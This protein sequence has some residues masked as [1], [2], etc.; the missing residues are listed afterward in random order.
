M[1]S[2]TR[3]AG[4]LLGLTLLAGVAACSSHVAA[5]GAGAGAAY[6]LTNR[7][8]EGMA[9]GSF[10]EV[11]QNSITVM[12]RMGITRT[13]PDLNEQD[14][15]ERELKGTIEDMDVVIELERRT[16]TNTL[17]QVTAKKS[18]VNYEKDFAQRIVQEIVEFSGAP[19][20]TPV[21]T[22]TMP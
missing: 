5:A 15:D 9:T 6:Y 14:G 8:A 13:D 20:A 10:D 2:R 21:E 18:E 7:G 1:I 17:V 11:T 4:S 22:D 3:L 19:T 16:D 12:E